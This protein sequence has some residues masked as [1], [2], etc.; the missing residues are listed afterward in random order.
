MTLEI[1]KF[2]STQN[3]YKNSNKMML[4]CISYMTSCS[5]HVTTLQCVNT[6]SRRIVLNGLNLKIKKNNEIPTSNFYR[7][8]AY[9]IIHRDSGIP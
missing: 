3:M 4:F 6:A 1:R 9:N 8:I 2:T 5:K 7:D